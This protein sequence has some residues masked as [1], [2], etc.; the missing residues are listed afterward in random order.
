MRKHK[1]PG[2]VLAVYMTGVRPSFII[3]YPKKYISLKFYTKNYLAQE[4]SFIPNKNTIL[5]YLD[6]DLFNQTDFKT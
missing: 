5:K 6:T 4:P 1:S 3:A 2:R